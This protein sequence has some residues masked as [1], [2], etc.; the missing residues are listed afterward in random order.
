MTLDDIPGILAIENEAFAGHHPWTAEAFQQ[1]LKN[2]SLAYYLVMLD[3]DK[4]IGYGGMWIILDEAHITN[5][6]L[7]A[8]YRGQGLGGCFVEQM[9]ALARLYGAESMTLEVRPSNGVA[10]HVYEKCGFRSAGRRPGYYED[11]EDAIIMWA[12]IKR[13]TA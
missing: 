8:D 3:G 13:P 4:L 2:N 6:A 12:T 9:Q 11:G 5:I 10:Q 7:H 1:E